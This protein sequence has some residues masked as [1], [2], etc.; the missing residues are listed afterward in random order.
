M[1]CKNE[2]DVADVQLQLWDVLLKL[3]I[4][5]KDRVY[6]GYDTLMHEFLSS[7]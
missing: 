7:K 2:V 3:G 1:L 4:K 6:K 5:P